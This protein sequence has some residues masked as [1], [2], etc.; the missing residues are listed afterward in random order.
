M[1]RQTN[2]TLAQVKGELASSRKRCFW[3]NQIGEIMEE[4]GPE[5]NEAENFLAELLE[6]EDPTD[7]FFGFCYLAVPGRELSADNQAKLDNFNADP[8]KTGIIADAQAA[9]NKRLRGMTGMAA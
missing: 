2:L 4:G 5:A 7:N 9:I 3:L 1:G 8:T 6:G